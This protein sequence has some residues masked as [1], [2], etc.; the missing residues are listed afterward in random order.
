MFALVIVE[1]REVIFQV[2]CYCHSNCL[3]PLHAE[4]GDKGLNFAP[5]LFISVTFHQKLFST[6]DLPE[7]GNI[8]HTFKLC[9]YVTC[10]TC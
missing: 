5:V 9:M 1:C 4:I 10:I 7:N 6:R 3:H 2:Y 8:F